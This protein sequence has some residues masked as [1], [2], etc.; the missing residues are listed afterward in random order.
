[1]SDQRNERNGLYA[2][3]L[4]LALTGGLGAVHAVAA[5]TEAKEAPSDIWLESRLITAYTLNPH[6]SPLELDVSVDEGVATVSGRVDNAIEHD[7]ALEIARGVEGIHKVMDEIRVKP[8]LVSDGREPSREKDE[9]GPGF[10]GS[11][12]DATITASVKMRLMWNRHTDGLDIDV[13]THQGRV[14]LEGVVAD[15]VTRDLAGEIAGNTNDVREVDN[16]LRVSARTDESIGQKVGKAVDKAG[17]VISDSW[18]TTKVYAQLDNDDVIDSTDIRVTTQE[19]KVT[20]SGRVGS[21]IERQ[22]APEI[23]ADVTGVTAIENRLEV[24]ERVSQQ[25]QQR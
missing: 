20:L 14:T 17:E 15:D 22:R 7:L 11:V 23:A 4:A 8:V 10:A 1:M 25:T 6:L 21:E 16:R 5:E 18:I 9:D 3:V 13:T 12:K 24:E 19:G 2:G